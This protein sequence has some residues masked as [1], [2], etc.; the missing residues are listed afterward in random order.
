M[1]TITYF[2]AI[3]SILFLNFSC[4]GPK[5]D[6]GIDGKDANVGS[7]IYDVNPSNWSGNVDGFVT[8]LIVPEL[9]EDIFYNGVVLVYMIKKENSADKNFN[10][11]PYTWLSN[12]NTEYMDY[13][14][15][16][17]KID[18]TIR[19]D[20]YGTNDTAAPTDY[21][22]FKVIIIP[23]TSLSV[24]EKQTNLSNPDNVI[25]FLSKQKTF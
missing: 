8:T 21:Y 23:G 7:A 19:W 4:I 15:Y 10:Q 24:L 16:I 22:T 14:A 11:L 18:I 2:L 17:G 5:G 20:D 25:D 3:I 13:D 1:K 9:T 6:D 12:N